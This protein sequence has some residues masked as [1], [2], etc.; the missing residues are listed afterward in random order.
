[1]TVCRICG[2]DKEPSQFHRIKNGTQF[3]SKTKLWCRVCQ[4]LWMD[5]KKEEIR[6]KEL[7]TKQW[8]FSVSFH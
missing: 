4:K 5:K 6:T 1:M 3:I 2:E 7:E 8:Q